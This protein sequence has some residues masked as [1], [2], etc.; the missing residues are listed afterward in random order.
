MQRLHSCTARVDARAYAPEIFFQAVPNH[1]DDIIVLPH[2][3]WR[4]IQAEPHESIMFL[5]ALAVH[6]V[7]HPSMADCPRIIVALPGETES[8][9]IADWLRAGRFEPVRRADP[10]A[11]ARDMHARAFDLL[12]TDSTFA[13]RDGL[14]ALSCQRN[15]STPAVVIGNG[16]DA[17]PCD[18]VSGHAMYVGRPL[19]RATLLCTVSM[20][21]ME[22]RP[23]RRSAR[24]L[25]NHFD[26]VVNNV[27]LQII[28]ASHHGLRLKLSQRIWARSGPNQMTPMIWCGAALSANRPATEEGWRRFVNM[29]PA[30]GESS[31]RPVSGW[32]PTARDTARSEAPLVNSVSKKNDEVAEDACWWQVIFSCLR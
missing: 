10:R 2:S 20:A 30:I 15:P 18:A 5:L 14:V 22:G 6:Y 3:L 24:K 29:L 27:P 7:T 25:A 21:M 4:A 9:T 11:A 19:D 12:I 13:I 16:G 28:D 26:A 32:D 1:L 31:T 23:T 17:D 8:A